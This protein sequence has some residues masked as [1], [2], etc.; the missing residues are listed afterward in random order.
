MLT[1]PFLMLAAFFLGCI[2]TEIR[3]I[4]KMRRLRSQVETEMAQVEAM[5]STDA[6]ASGVQRFRPEGGTEQSLLGLQKHLSE[7]AQASPV[8]QGSAEV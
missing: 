2:G 6:A 3:W 7:E 8:P 1:E 4:A 5:I